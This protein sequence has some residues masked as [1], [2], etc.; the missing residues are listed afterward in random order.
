MPFDE[1]EQQTQ[2]I[3]FDFEGQIFRSVMIDGEP[4]FVAADVCCALGIA[5]SRDAINRLD[6]DEVKTI[7]V[8]DVD[9]ADGIQSSVDNADGIWSGGRGNPNFNIV[10]ESGLYALVF[11]S[12]K[13]L[14]RRFRKW[15][16]SEVLPALR[17]QGH[18]TAPGRTP[19]HD[20][21][22]RPDAAISAQRDWEGW[23]S[24][25]REA[26]LVHGTRAARKI[27]A[28]SPL[29]SLDDDEQMQASE[30][31]DDSR[32]ILDFIRARYEVTGDSADRVRASDMADDLM[33]WQRAQCL[34]VWPKGRC[35]RQLAKFFDHWTDP[36][37]GLRVFRYK[38][39][40]MV[41]VG[42]VPKDGAL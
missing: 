35:T 42:I 28:Q 19:G 6:D 25:V 22:P 36:A 39:S 21:A 17:R 40:V 24:A 8:R 4:W 33:D 38:A 18:Y 16:T 32:V 10:S 5:N 27:W 11:T 26:R 15:V 20:L 2:I 3:P 23:L 1:H 14:A 9:S 29:P 7:N 30:T 37:T 13:P 34:P 31:I 41:C 12:R